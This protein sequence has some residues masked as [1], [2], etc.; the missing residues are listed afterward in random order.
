MN[1]TKTIAQALANKA[2]TNLK[3]EHQNRVANYVPDEVEVQAVKLIADKLI[4]A[5]KAE[6]EARKALNVLMPECFI[7]TCATSESIVKDFTIRQA[8][9][10]VFKLPSK[11]T[12]VDDFLIASLDANNADE[13]INMVTSKYTE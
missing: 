9:K 12:L 13:L 4:E 6:A 11:D 2:F 5:R 3:K 10:A 7:T 1:F 8:N